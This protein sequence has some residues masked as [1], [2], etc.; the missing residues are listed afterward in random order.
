MSSSTEKRAKPTRASR[1]KRR[2]G[3]GTCKTR[4]KRC[5]EEKPICRNC[6]S[7]GRLC[8]GYIDPDTGETFGGHAS[9][10]ISS[11]I[12]EASILRTPSPH[13]FRNQI[14]AQ[15]FRFFE[16][17]TSVIITTGLQSAEWKAPVLQLGHQDVSVRHGLIALGVLTRRFKKNPLSTNSCPEANVLH[18]QALLHHGQAAAQL[19][20]YLAQSETTPFFTE[21]ILTTC[22]LLGLFNLL[23]GEPVALLSN[24]TKGFQTVKLNGTT[25]NLSQYLLSLLQQL[26]A[27][28]AM[29]LGLDRTISEGPLSFDI[30]HTGPRLPLGSDLT[31]LKYELALLNHDIMTFRCLVERAR[32]SGSLPKNAD[33]VKA[34]LEHRLELLYD[35]TSKAVQKDGAD[36]H[37]SALLRVCYLSAAMSVN[38]I[39]VEERDPAI[40]AAP[41]DTDVDLRTLRRS[42]E[43]LSICEE[44]FRQV[45]PPTILE[46]LDVLEPIENL[47]VVPL[48]AFHCGFI[49]A[50]YQVA[51]VAPDITLRM[52]ACSLLIEKPWREGGWDSVIMGSI[53]RTYTEV[54]KR[55]L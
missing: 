48:L 20:S 9:Q 1:P 27:L 30:L 26:D 11:R 43:T 34:V 45:D 28:S 22:L 8:D 18:S 35:A 38:T 39:K 24:V 50:L 33:E 23:R 4:H 2:T 29:W 6:G 41:R 10:R 5:D 51:M 54:N 31:S 44:I 7:T 46:R 53:A 25:S 55:W 17:V 3:C 21:S 15:G 47:G 16:S 19:A 32:A 49:P 12:P 37:R 40:E 13:I 36:P 14:E 52:R 42:T